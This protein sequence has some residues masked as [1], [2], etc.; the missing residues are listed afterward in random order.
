VP[1]L[2]CHSKCSY[3]QRNC[4]VG[5]IRVLT[6]LSLNETQLLPTC[7]VSPIKAFIKEFIYPLRRKETRGKAIEHIASQC[8]TRLLQPVIPTGLTPS[9]FCT[10]GIVMIDCFARARLSVVLFT[11]RCIS[12][13]A[14]SKQKQERDITAQRFSPREQK[15]R[16]SLFIR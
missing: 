15:G 13:T 8:L 1:Q 11:L 14:F 16:S 2:R 10:Q 4:T 5:G 3:R 6:T 12:D 7:R 9:C